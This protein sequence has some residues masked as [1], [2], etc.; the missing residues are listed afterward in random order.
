MKQLLIAIAIVLLAISC[1]QKEQEQASEENG[2]EVVKPAIGKY[3]YVDS[4]NV[5]HVDKD[6]VPTKSPNYIQFVD[7]SLVTKEDFKGYCPSCVDDNIYELIAQ[8]IERNEAK[9][10][11]RKKIIG[12]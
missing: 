4:H 9:D 1:Q 11:K 2:E 3:L 10:V 12:F 6:C 8:M 7:T 5:L